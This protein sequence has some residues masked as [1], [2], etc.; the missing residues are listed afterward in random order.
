MAARPVPR[1][2]LLVCLALANNSK[3]RLK[4]MIAAA[5]GVLDNNVRLTARERTHYTQAVSV[6]EA[7]YELFDKISKLRVPAPPPAAVRKVG[8]PSQK[9][10]DAASRR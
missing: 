1:R 5:Q 4:T 7:M 3:H 2:A 8:R 9:E 6:A 10:I